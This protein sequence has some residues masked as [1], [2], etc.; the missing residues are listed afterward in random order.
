MIAQKKFTYLRVM[1][2][3]QSKQ[4]KLD[5]LNLS[6]IQST[7]DLPGYNRAYIVPTIN[8]RF[9]YRIS[10]KGEVVFLIPFNIFF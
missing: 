9:Y 2:T 10:N 1:Q 5:L 3:V 6:T 7:D 8:K 4:K